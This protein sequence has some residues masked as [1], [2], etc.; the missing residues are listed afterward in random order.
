[1]AL[2]LADVLV[3]Q[4]NRIFSLFDQTESSFRFIA[5]NCT[6]SSVEQMEAFAGNMI[7]VRSRR[8]KSVVVASEQ[9]FD[10]LKAPIKMVTAPHTPVPFADNLEDLYKP[11]AENIAAAVR[12]VAEY[13]RWEATASKS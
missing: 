12:S 4:L 5:N 2:S 3:A 7:E 1:M 8:G 10:A 13:Q 6:P 11:G 9:A